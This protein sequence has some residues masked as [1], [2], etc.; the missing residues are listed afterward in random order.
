MTG[1]HAEAITGCAR[2][3]ANATDVGIPHGLVHRLLSE[4]MGVRQGQPADPVRPVD[5]V[6]VL[7]PVRALQACIGDE[8]LI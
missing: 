5:R 4:R 2:V 6:E 1:H 7:Y 8:R 3:Q